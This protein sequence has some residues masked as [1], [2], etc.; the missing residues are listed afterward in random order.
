MGRMIDLVIS[1]VLLSAAGYMWWRINRL[2]RE[3]VE[4]RQRMADLEEHVREL[5]R[6]MDAFD[7]RLARLE[8]RPEVLPSWVEQAAPPHKNGSGGD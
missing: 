6:R 5:N 3:M 4:M 2:W 8:G 7:R 1:V